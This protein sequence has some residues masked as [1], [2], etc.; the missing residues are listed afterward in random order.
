MEFSSIES[1]WQK[2]WADAKLFEADAKAG[3]PKYFVNF[4]YPYM[5]SFLHIGH[6]YTWMRVEAMARY[7]RLQGFHVL[8]PQGWHCTGSPIEN[9]AMRVRE[10]EPKQIEQ[11]KQLGLSDTQIESFGDPKKWVEFFPVE[12]KKDVQAL[13]FSIDW[14]RSFITT[15]LNPHYDRFIAWQFEKLREKKLIEQGEHPVVWCLKDH[16]PVPDH[17]RLEGEGEK[18]QEF[19]LLKFQFEKPNRF[20][21]AATLRPETVFGQTNLWVHPD[22]EYAIAQVDNAE[23]WIASAAFFDKLQ[24]QKHDV[25]RI[26]K[27]SGK[28]LLNQFAQAP[29]IKRQIPILPAFFCDPAKGTGIVTSV[30]SDA[31][32]DYIGLRDL[33]TDP[34]QA[35]KLGVDPQILG[36]I[37]PI[38]IIDSTELGDMAAVTIV[39]QM[40]IKNQFERE[41]LE[42]AKQIAYKKGFYSGKMKPIA[43]K[44]AGRPVIE[45]KE[46]VKEEL[47]KTNQAT[48][49]FELSNPVV[50]RCLTP[51]IVKIVSNQ[52]FLK[53]GDEAWKA[54]TRKALEKLRLY[55]PESRTQFENALE[56]LNDWACTR[57]LGL[58]TRLP[59]DPQWV[60]ESLSD[61]TL[62]MAYYTIAHLVQQIPIEQVNSEL[63]DF[64]FLGKNSKNVKVPKD[65]LLQMK[66]E[67]EYWYPFDFRNSGKDL[68]NNHYL[69]CLF[70]HTA[71]FPEKHW[72]KGLSVNGWV[73]VNGEKMSKS[74]ANFI[75]FRELPQKFGADAS[76]FASAYSGE[77]LDDANFDSVLAGSI[78]AKLEQFASLAREHFQKGRS[79][80]TLLDDWFETRLNTILAEGTAHMEN[81]RFRSAIQVLFFD[82]QREFKWYLRRANQE[83]N[84]E[85][86]SRA[87]LTQTVVL[88]PFTP[89]FCEEL[90]EKLAIPR[91]DKGFV[92]AARWP[93]VSH[94]KPNPAADLQEEL[95]QKTMDDVAQI[96]KITN[97]T[98]PILI[99]LYT[100][101]AWKTKALSIY[102]K[103]SNKADIGAAMKAL[104]ADAEIKKHGNELAGFLKTAQKNLVELP[105]GFNEEKAL[106]ENQLFLESEFG[107]EVRI[108]PAEKSDH[109]KAKNAFPLKPAILI[110]NKN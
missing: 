54:R 32:D 39:N 87:I 98:Q 73:L 41:K 36:N 20:L 18:P 94:A 76:R 71:V 67:F 77:G 69:F 22:A 23:E 65:K 44:F 25:K 106:Q 19:V 89:H 49:F 29:M 70:N 93:E 78:N 59:W 110:A 40:K 51:A 34:A 17:A 90:Y 7:K 108:I 5:N 45:A 31:P 86:I 48:L 74:R 75:L 101:P 84:R 38:P 100:A 12:A 50:C 60:I 15:E 33:Q 88:S 55:P 64:I 99:T 35:K 61:S 66:K 103:L 10:K 97:A 109:P 16:S 28:K 105:A 30:P 42:E 83:P 68:I 57:E 81:A 1:K 37:K 62:Y 43:G 27:I 21:V 95:I 52:W 4:P 46:K 80:R 13:G 102:A 82:L 96:K 58:G 24:E 107:C 47:L 56:W 85:L 63:F 8:F 11:L 53:Y 79:N 104:T 91:I 3:T 92:S 26:G 6:L 2:K 14:R 9:A 72:P